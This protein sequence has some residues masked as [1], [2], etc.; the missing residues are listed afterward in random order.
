MHV[1]LHSTTK[2]NI[3]LDIDD[4]M[5]YITLLLCSAQLAIQQA[6][7]ELLRLYFLSAQ[8]SLKPRLHVSVHPQADLF[9]V[10]AAVAQPSVLAPTWLILVC[11]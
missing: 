1:S 7:V 6:V 10:A 5:Y 9:A 3:R 11:V 4:I 8:L 2:I